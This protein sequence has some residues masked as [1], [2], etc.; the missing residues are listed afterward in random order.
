MPMCRIGVGMCLRPTARCS[1]RSMSHQARAPANGIF[2]CNSSMRRIIIWP[3][4][5]AEHV[6][7]LDQQWMLPVG[8]RLGCTSCCCASPASVLSPGTAASATWAL[9]AAGC[10]RRS[11]LLLVAAVFTSD[12]LALGSSGHPYRAAQLCAAST[13]LRNGSV[14]DAAG[15]AIRPASGAAILLSGSSFRL[16]AC[17]A[18]C[19]SF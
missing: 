14:A 11:L 15:S 5:A 4:L 12:V 13:C 7:R 6:S 10:A 19:G 16:C 8:D 17:R 9:I 18:D 1:A 2:K 3:R